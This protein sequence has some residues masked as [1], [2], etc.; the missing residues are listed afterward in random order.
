MIIVCTSEKGG[1]GKSCFAQNSAV[2]MAQKG[3]Q[4]CLVDADPQK[5]TTDW[6]DE[7]RSSKRELTNLSCFQ[8]V[9]KIK[10][11]LLK[12]EEQFDCIV[13]DC[14]GHKSDTMIHA[15]LAAT[16]II[17]PMRPKRRDL[18]TMASFSDVISNIMPLNP[19][20]IVRAVI[21]QA[22]TLP[23]QA[24]RI[25][26]SK[27]VCRSFGIEVLNYIICNRNIYDD[28]DEGGLSVF[29]SKDD[30]KATRE[31]ESVMNELLDL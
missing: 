25:L 27:D 3:L 9:G 19:N 14:G 16:H 8:L 12:L 11:D 31:F 22:P 26:E 7:R 4:V 10:N 29:E 18:K 28:C 30:I 1:P 23:S 24:R 5:T 15:M 13:V 17:V 20:V 21:N 2:F 6:I